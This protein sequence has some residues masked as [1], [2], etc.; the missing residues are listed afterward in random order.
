MKNIEFIRDSAPGFRAWIEALLG[1]VITFPPPLLGW[2]GRPAPALIAPGSDMARL[3][4]QYGGDM[5]VRAL[6][7]THRDGTYRRVHRSIRRRGDFGLKVGY[8]HS[9]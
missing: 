2:V 8:T 1:R 9:G 5:D 3:A 4:E 7:R 6:G